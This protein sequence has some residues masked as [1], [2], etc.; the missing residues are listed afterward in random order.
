[1]FE[2]VA[3]QGIRDLARFRALGW[4]YGMTDGPKKTGNGHEQCGLY[5]LGHPGSSG[6]VRRLGS[7]SIIS[8]R[9]IVIKSQEPIASFEVTV[10]FAEFPVQSASNLL[11]T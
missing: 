9:R 6:N 5:D 8:N 3:Y 2:P 4:R 1:V 10:P 7:D 11:E